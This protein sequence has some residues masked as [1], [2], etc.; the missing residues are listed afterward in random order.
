MGAGEQRVSGDDGGTLIRGADGALYY[1][2]DEKLKGYLLSEEDAKGLRGELD[3][4]ESVSILG[5]MRGRR[6]QELGLVEGGSTTVSVVNLGAARQ[7]RL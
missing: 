5:T 3:R 4:Q 2:S 6:V 7:W 1:I